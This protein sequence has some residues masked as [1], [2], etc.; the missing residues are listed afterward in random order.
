M[1]KIARKFVEQVRAAESPKDLYEPIQNAI[2]LELATIPPYL[3]ALFTLKSGADPEFR[4]IL[5]AIAKDEMLHL[6]IMGNLMIALKGVPEIIAAAR[7]VEYPRRLPMNVGNSVVVTLEKCSVAQA[8]DV[9][10]KIEEPE[11]PLVFEALA[12]VDYAT[13]GEF[14]RALVARI[15]ALG[16]AEFDTNVSKQVSMGGF[17]VTVAPI[18]NVK[19][20]RDAILDFIVQQGEGTTTSPQDKQG[21]FAHYY[22][23]QQIVKGR[24]LKS[25]PTAPFWS[26]SGDDLTLDPAQVW[27]MDGNPKAAQYPAG[28]AARTAVDAFNALYSSM[29][30]SLDA[31][32]K[33]DPAMLDNAI[34]AMTDMPGAAATVLAIP[35]RW[36]TGTQAGLPFEYG[37]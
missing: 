36:G 24:K 15:E 12:A 10:M 20:A 7:A 35:S 9:F 21:K 8:R 3:C 22:R 18:T 26:F 1:L 4:R 11:D 13:I 28:D 27:D 14:Y 34:K 32:F 2:T 33:G 30:D 31:A 19:T 6:A 23:F 17:G 16:D 25:I 29:I 37:P 5:R